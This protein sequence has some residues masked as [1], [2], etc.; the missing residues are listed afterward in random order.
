MNLGCDYCF[1]VDCVGKG[2]GLALFWKDDS[3]LSIVSYSKGHIDAI[4]KEGSGDWRF[5]GFYGNP[6]VEERKESWKLLERLNE[7]F[8]LPW[9][10]G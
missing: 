7:L 10:V 4:I 6:K 3:K 2:G 5:T 8:D 1:A 9:V